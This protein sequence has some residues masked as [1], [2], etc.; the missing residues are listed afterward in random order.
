MKWPSSPR[1]AAGILYLMLAFFTGAV[2]AMYV[3]YSSA[4]QF[5]DLFPTSE[6]KFLLSV[7][8][9]LFVMSLALGLSLLRQ[10]RVGPVTALASVTAIAVA[11]AWNFVVPLYWLLP[12][13]LVFAAYRQS[14]VIGKLQ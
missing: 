10:P 7:T 14:K 11:F 4:T 6:A 5:A 1:I 12:A 2:V 13:L 9:G 3:T 8:A